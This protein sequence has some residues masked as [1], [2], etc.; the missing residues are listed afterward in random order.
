MTRIQEVEYELLSKLA[1]LFQENKI[2]YWLAYGSVLGSVRHSGFIPWDDDID[3]Y[4]RGQDY[5]KV[6]CM[7][8]NNDFFLRFEDYKNSNNYPFHFP[9]II[10]T[11]TK[12]IEKRF[13]HS[14]YVCGI[15]IDIFPLYG[16]SSNFF[17]RH[18]GYF[19][20]YFD[21]AIIEAHS[22]KAEKDASYIKRFFIRILSFF[23]V[24]KAQRRLHDR[25]MKGFS[26]KS[27]YLSE[28]NLFKDK[29]LDI[30]KCFDGYE[31]SKF[32]DLSV[33]I[34]LNSHEYL[35]RHYG[36]YMQF[37]PA[38]KRCSC[39]NFVYVEYSDGTSQKGV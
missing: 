35:C 16:V 2:D 26:E 23:N 28:P 32:E 25:Y 34:P 18:I 10:D 3:I 5:E 21:Y 27:N 7:L 22:A 11:R 39:H 20:R 8:E 19:T 4:I 37:P 24:Q 9:K 15:Y 30:A 29:D 31:V 38:E 36:D 14:Q 17:L 33:K 12:L 13:M 1:L 6:R